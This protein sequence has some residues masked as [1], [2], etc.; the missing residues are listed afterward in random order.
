MRDKSEQQVEF[1][2]GLADMLACPACHEDLRL[3]GERLVCGGCGR[4]F[5]VIDGIPVLIEE[6]A[7]MGD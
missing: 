1:D 7:D 3:D 5:P 4:R 2:P 6:G